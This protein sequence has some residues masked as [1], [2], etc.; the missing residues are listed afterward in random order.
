MRGKKS[1][2][3]PTSAELN[4]LKILWTIEPATVKQLHIKVMEYQDTGYTTVLKTLQIMHEKGLVA[5]D[6]SNRA[7]KYT[8][9][10]SQEQTQSSLLSDM[11]HK[12]FDGSKSQLVMRA[13]GEKASE[14]EIAEIR[15]LL[16]SLE[17]KQ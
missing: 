12:A 10:Y 5:R 4:L 3:V 7:H 9:T 16:N 15:D 2:V 17:K 14:G 11:M 8:A 6:E 1:K 13:L